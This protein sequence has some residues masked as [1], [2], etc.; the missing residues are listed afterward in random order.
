MPEAPGSQ[1][2]ARYHDVDKAI[3]DGYAAPNAAEC[4]EVP[5]V[6]AMGI[7]SVNLSLA[8]DQ[9]VDPTKPELLLYAP[10]N[11]GGF[12]LVGIEWF[13]PVDGPN[14]ATPRPALFGQGFDGPM[15]GHEPG[16]PWHYD[17]HVWAWEPNP[18]GTFAQFNPNVSC[19][20]K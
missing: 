19:A 11:G 10:K 18:N 4:V 6:G 9:A 7:H 12:K 20:V 1:A 5:G 17:L 15:A 8:M 14:T 3:A 13:L 2:T 16:Q